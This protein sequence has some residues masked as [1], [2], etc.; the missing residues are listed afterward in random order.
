MKLDEDV[1]I[2]KGELVNPIS[3]IVRRVSGLYKTKKNTEMKWCGI[4][5]SLVG[6]SK[7]SSDST[8]VNGNMG[9]LLLDHKLPDGTAANLIDPLNSR[10]L[11]GGYKSTV[12]AGLNAPPEHRRLW[13]EDPE[14]YVGCI[15]YDNLGVDLLA[16]N[17]LLTLLLLPCSIFSTRPSAARCRWSAWVLVP[18]GSF[19]GQR[20]R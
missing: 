19:P 10:V 9:N 3:L 16:D 2:E 1:E 7:R 17:C 18:L 6:S 12:Y 11:N 14:G 13:I 20:E 15:L 4:Q 8:K 5:I